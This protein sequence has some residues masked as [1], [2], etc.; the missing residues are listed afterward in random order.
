[1]DSITHKPF[2]LWQTN[3]SKEACKRTR[4]Y[5]RHLQGC[6]DFIN[7]SLKWFSFLRLVAKATRKA[8]V[9]KREFEKRLRIR[10]GNQSFMWGIY[11]HECNVAKKSNRKNTNWT[12]RQSSNFRVTEQSTNK[13]YEFSILF[14]PIILI[15]MTYNIVII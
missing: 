15:Y 10:G 3:R 8:T 9:F 7:M 11:N 1:M 2:I 12:D 13:R 4:V 6:S 14:I 5:Q